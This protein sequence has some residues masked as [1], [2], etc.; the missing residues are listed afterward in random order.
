MFLFLCSDCISQIWE[1]DLHDNFRP[2][3]LIFYKSHHTPLT[4]GSCFWWIC[5]TSFV[6]AFKRRQQAGISA[7][8]RRFFFFMK[9]VCSAC[10]GI[11]PR[12]RRTGNYLKS[13][14][15]LEE[16]YGGK[17]FTWE[18]FSES[19]GFICKQMTVTFTDTPWVTKEPAKLVLVEERRGRK[20]MYKQL[21]FLKIL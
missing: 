17:I 7:I 19:L 20:D 6:K 2:M 1:S 21:G 3:D 13:T 15:R 4:E 8:Y 11:L 16:C 18:S 14:R 10:H 5:F 12:G 9:S